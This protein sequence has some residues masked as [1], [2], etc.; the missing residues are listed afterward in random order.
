MDDEL[1]NI[2]NRDIKMVISVIKD[3]KY[4]GMEYKKL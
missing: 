3:E 4:R 1:T 2:A